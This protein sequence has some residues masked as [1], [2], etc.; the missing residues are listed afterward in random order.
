MTDPYR[1]L[2]IFETPVKWIGQVAH[3]ASRLHSMII[4][5]PI[6]MLMLASSELIANENSLVENVDLQMYVEV[7][8]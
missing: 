8:Y 1:H 4:S 3:L 5:S 6:I 2:H 7:L